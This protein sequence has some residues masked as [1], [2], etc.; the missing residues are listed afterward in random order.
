MK[1]AIIGK[2]NLGTHLYDALKSVVSVQWYARDYPTSMDADLVIVSVSDKETLEV[3]ERI[4]AALV[5]HTAGIVP[6]VDRPNAGVLYPLYSF[7]K[8]AAVDWANVPFLIETAQENNLSIL[9]ETVTLLGAKFYSM[10]S[11]QRTKIHAA[12][13]IVNNFTNH[14]Y[15]LAEDYCRD[16]N[17]PFEVL[18]G[19]MQQGP[20]KAIELGAK[21]AQTGPAI[22][23]DHDTIENHLESIRQKEIK[24]LYEHISTSIRN[25]H[26]L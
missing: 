7:T 15:T 11:A 13:V 1:I 26:E 23:G 22:R 8:G 6:R 17:L 12:A 16:H 2:G 20:S 19:I 21:Q 14:L 4:D 5:V 25:R 18:H 10:S 9:K 3:C 24:E